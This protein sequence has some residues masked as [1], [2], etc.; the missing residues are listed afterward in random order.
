MY[1]RALR[2]G[3]VFFGFGNGKLAT[4]LAASAAQ[5]VFTGQAWQ[6]GARLVHRVAPKSMMA[7]V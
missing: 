3:L 4:R 7:W 1:M 5:S 6:L 2:A